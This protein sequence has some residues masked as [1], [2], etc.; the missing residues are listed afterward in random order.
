M[1]TIE[2]TRATLSNY[3]MTYCASVHRSSKK[4]NSIVEMRINGS[5]ETALY[6][7]KF[8]ERLCGLL[9]QPR[10]EMTRLLVPCNSVH[11]FGM[12]DEID[13]AFITSSGLVLEVMNNVGPNN[14]LSNKCAS[15]VA[16]RFSSE[17]RWMF[18]GDRVVIGPLCLKGKVEVR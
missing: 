1:E 10:D 2:D 15:F 14:L 8:K 13:I 9:G 16:E 11:T 17:R 5:V 3:C 18:E 4:G 6:L 12:K 7:N